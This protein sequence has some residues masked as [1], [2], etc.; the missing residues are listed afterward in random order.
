LA[1]ERILACAGA[2]VS[3]VSALAWVFDG[4]ASAK[5]IAVNEFTSMPSLAT[6]GDQN[7]FVYAAS[8]QPALEAFPTISLDLPTTISPALTSVLRMR[9]SAQGP[10]IRVTV[11]ACSE[12]GQ[13]LACGDAFG[14]LRIF[15]F[16]SFGETGPDGAELEALTRT[17]TSF[18]Q[19]SVAIESLCWSHD[20]SYIVVGHAGGA[21]V[22]ALKS[23]G[24]AGGVQLQ[25]PWDKLAL[26]SK[27]RVVALAAENAYALTSCISLKKGVRYYLARH[28]VSAPYRKFPHTSDELESGRLAALQELTAWMPSSSPPDLCCNLDSA[29]LGAVIHPSNQSVLVLSASGIVTIHEIWSGEL[30]GIFSMMPVS[31]LP[32]T[33]IGQFVLDPSGLYVGLVSTSG[34]KSTVELHQLLTGKHEASVPLVPSIGRLTS[35]SW[36][37]CGNYLALG[38]TS[39]CKLLELPKQVRQNIHDLRARVLSKDPAYW[40]T[41]PLYLPPFPKSAEELK[42]QLLSAS[43]L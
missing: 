3:G 28:K 41:H 40:R 11:L 42:A 32:T 18:A 17:S 4:S 24:F 22:A 29:C 26:H 1:T 39:G 43:D 15:R 5:G 37:P 35:A 27:D 20:L 34:V 30:R 33:E 9:S 10:C 16:S 23:K 14:D 8:S 36:S 19:P 7:I 31:R 25:V 38:S 2:H 21:V 6:A 13:F 12:D